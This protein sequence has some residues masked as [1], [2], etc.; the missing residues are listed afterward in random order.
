MAAR[1]DMFAAA[2]LSGILAMR[3]EDFL[4]FRAA[5]EVDGKLLGACSLAWVIAD[6]MIKVDPESDDD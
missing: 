4:S 2:A 6:E 5:Y 3:A 1:R